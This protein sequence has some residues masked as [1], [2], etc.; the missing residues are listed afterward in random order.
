MFDYA[1]AAVEAGLAAGARFG[2]RR[3]VVSRDQRLRAQDGVLEDLSQGE[4]AGLG[5]RALNGAGWGHSATPSLEMRDVRR[6][7]E[8]AASAARAAASVP[9][10]DAV[11]LP[12]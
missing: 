4:S 8:Q 5:V 6:A 10:P 3:V 9:G 7:G 11:L 12:E 1:Q 2:A